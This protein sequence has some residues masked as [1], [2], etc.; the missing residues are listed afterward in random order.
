MGMHVGIYMYVCTLTMSACEFLRQV[1]CLQIACDS[2]RVNIEF[3]PPTGPTPLPIH[4]ARQP[5]HD[6][7]TATHNKHTPPLPA[8][9]VCPAYAPTTTI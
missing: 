3:S 9:R 6:T 1:D 2:D 8:P 4:P 7:H 5:A